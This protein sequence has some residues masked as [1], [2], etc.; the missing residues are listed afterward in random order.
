[1]RSFYFAVFYLS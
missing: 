1:L